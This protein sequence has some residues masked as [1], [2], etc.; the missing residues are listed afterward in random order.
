M[1]APG[2]YKTPASAPQSPP[3]RYNT[4]PWWSP[5]SQPQTQNAYPQN[6]YQQNS[7][8]QNSYPQSSYPQNTQTITLAAENYVPDMNYNTI[9]ASQQQEQEQAPQPFHIVIPDE[10]EPQRVPVEMPVPNNW[11]MLQ[12]AQAEH[13]QQ[14][15]EQQHF[16]YYP[17]RPQDSTAP[18]LFPLGARLPL[19]KS[20]FSAAVVSKYQ[21]LAS[22]KV[23]VFSAVD[24][25]HLPAEPRPLAIADNTQQ[26]YND[27]DE[28]Y[29]GP[30]EKPQPKEPQNAHPQPFY[31]NAVYYSSPKDHTPITE[32]PAE[33]E[34]QVLA[35]LKAL[36]P[37]VTAYGFVPT[38][39][40]KI[41]A[42]APSTMLGPLPVPQPA[43]IKSVKKPQP[44][45]YSS[46]RGSVDS[47][48]VEVS[49][50]FLIRTSSA[51]LPEIRLRT[52]NEPNYSHV[53]LHEQ[54]ANSL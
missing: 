22:I 52:S 28:V 4:Q 50:P 45:S 48:P 18:V 9:Q 15:M 31:P 19:P 51:R 21:T 20:N 34:E 10:R 41:P 26:Y 37:T 32:P 3:L 46:F 40:V 47:R 25:Y 12:D 11:F 24:F 39:A 2:I 6:S 54:R 44:I 7:Y 27:L 23:P 16:Q 53:S 33:G 36:K 29:R 49:V 42:A 17:Q 5:V 14:P 13:L 38:A 35:Q 8:Q 43:V 30:V 1:E